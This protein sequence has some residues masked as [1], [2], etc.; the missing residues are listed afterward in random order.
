MV[1]ALDG[2]STVRVTFTAPQGRFMNLS[3]PKLAF[4]QIAA[5]GAVFIDPRFMPEAPSAGAES[6]V[7]PVAGQNRMAVIVVGGSTSARYSLTVADAGGTSAID[8]LKPR[9]PT[10]RPPSSPPA[11]SR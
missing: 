1:N 5:D 3:R 8:L 2:A 10:R 9:R 4:V 7:V 11:P 6:W